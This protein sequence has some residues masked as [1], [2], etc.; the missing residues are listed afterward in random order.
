MPCRVG[1]T[2][3]PEKRKS[4]W[5]REVIGLRNWE[6]IGSYPTKSQAQAHED[7]YANQHGCIAAHGGAD[8]PGIWYVYRFDYTRSL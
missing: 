2:T 1:I 3:R 8:A 4:E 7:R 5:E 6:I